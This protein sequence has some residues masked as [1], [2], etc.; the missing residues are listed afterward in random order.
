LLKHINIKNGKDEPA[1]LPP[2]PLHVG[3]APHVT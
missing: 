3:P 1:V 2:L